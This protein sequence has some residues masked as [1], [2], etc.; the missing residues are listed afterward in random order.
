M[1]CKHALSTQQTTDPAHSIVLAVEHSV[2]EEQHDAWDALAS[3]KSVFLKR[4]YC[5]SVSLNNEN[6]TY[7]YACFTRDGALVG[8]AA[9][10]LIEAD[11]VVTEK[12]NQPHDRNFMKVARKL[13]KSSVI[14]RRLLV[15]GNSFATG[16]HGFAFQQEI[17]PTT[18]IALI[19]AASE[20]VIQQEKAAGRKISAV[21]IKDFFEHPY[22]LP[23]LFKRERYAEVNQAPTMVMPILPHWN[24]FDDY[25]DALTSKYRTKA[26]AVM[27]RSEEVHIKPLSAA[28]TQLHAGTL[29]QLY[30]DVR[31]RAAFR[32]GS[33]SEQ[34]LPEMAKAMG[35][36]FVVLGYF[37]KD[38][39]VGFQSCFKNCTCLDAHFVGFDYRL[40][41]R[42]GLYQRM[43]YEYIKMG[44]EEGYQ[45][46]NFGRT[47]TEIKS[48]VGALP[49]SMHCYMKH[50][51]KAPNLI[52]QTLAGFITHDDER[53]H[54]AY[55]KHELAE[56]VS[57]LP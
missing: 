21:L 55:R 6:L 16:E 54:I 20:R 10:Q 7:R 34:A 14:A 8:I 23:H 9:F 48:T 38:Q 26:R 32:I 5:E 33:L 13:I 12:P 50:T 11:A 22:H 4:S 43:L 52:M 53:S 37:F 56:V 2:A 1:T 49:V 24:H 27:N 45:R 18:Q 39:L 29:Y 41:H 46:I 17:D 57:L 51:S 36:D 44:I 3:E 30:A 15:L 25:L 42:L 19:T 31:D 40:N 47:A 35:A 28:E